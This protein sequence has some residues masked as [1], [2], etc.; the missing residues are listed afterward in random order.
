M[1]GLF[2]DCIYKAIS[3]IKILL[4]VLLVLGII[5]VGFIDNQ[6]IIQGYICVIFVSIPACALLSI[7][8]DIDSKWYKYELSLPVKKTRIIDVKYLSVAFWILISSILAIIYT[9]SVI[10]VK[11]YKYF[12]FGISDILTIF[13]ISFSFSLIMCSIFYLCLYLLSMDKS[14]VLILVSIIF[15]IVYIIGVTYLLN[16]ANITIKTGRIFMLIISVGVFLLSH[17]FTKIIY[18]KKEL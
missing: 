10:C 12:D 18:S 15:A 13:C 1:K 17:N 16:L 3:S 4:Y 9:I 8:K 7:R 2:R 11:G 6:L 14:D 5:I